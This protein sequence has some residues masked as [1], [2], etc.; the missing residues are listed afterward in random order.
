[1]PR[2]T[3]LCD[4]LPVVWVDSGELEISLEGVLETEQRSACAA[5]ALPQF[6]I[7]DFSWETVRLHEVLSIVGMLTSPTRSK[8]SV[9]GNLSCHW[10]CKRRLRQRR[11]KLFEQ[12]LLLPDEGGPVLAAIQECGQNTRAVDQQPCLLSQKVV[13]PHSL[14][15]LGHH[16]CHLAYPEAYFRIQ[17]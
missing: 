11:W 12:P 5:D 3:I 16:S 6:S 17:G 14:A 4:L 7:E 10:I 15:Q 9:L 1:M 2:G 8:A 13:V